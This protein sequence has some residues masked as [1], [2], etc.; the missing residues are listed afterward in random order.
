M[1]RHNKCVQQGLTYGCIPIICHGSQEKAFSCHKET[2]EPHLCCTAHKRDGFVPCKNVTQHLGSY[3]R[4]G[5][6]IYK[7]Q[8]AEKKVHRCVQPGVQPYESDHPHI[9]PKSNK[10]NK[11][12]N[13]EDDNLLMEVICNATEEKLRHDSLILFFHWSVGI[14]QENKNYDL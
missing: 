7:G 14:C 12:K 13:D 10:I 11:E 2:K 4:R 6:H 8:L 9:T 1:W 5:R 3:G